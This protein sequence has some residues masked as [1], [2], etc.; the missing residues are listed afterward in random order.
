MNCGE[1]RFQFNAWLDTRRSGS[2]GRAALL[3]A[4]TCGGCA[5][6]ARALMRIDEGL[7][8]LAGVPVPGEIPV[9]GAEGRG[10]SAGWGN[11]FVYFARQGGALATAALLCWCFS[12]ALPAGWQVAARFLLASGAMCMFAVASLRPRFISC[13]A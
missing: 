1:F 2:P 6:Y 9:R 13:T 5:S 4:A 12:Y 7:H 8:A 3:H 11:D 10:G